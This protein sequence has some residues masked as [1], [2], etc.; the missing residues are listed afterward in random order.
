M[1]VCVCV[2]VCVIHVYNI[3]III[4][5]YI[6]HVHC[7]SVC[8]FLFQ[9]ILCV[10]LSYASDDNLARQPISKKES[11]QR[12]LSTADSKTSTLVA[13]LP[14]S[15]PHST[16]LSAINPLPPLPLSLSPPKTEDDDEFDSESYGGSQGGGDEFEYRHAR[17]VSH[18]IV[19]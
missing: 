15:T 3:T 14:V 13:S 9:D 5:M 2:C 12:T 10:L 4:I 19:T 7:S 1:C 17:H 6:V 18:V 8:Q 16:T 11:L